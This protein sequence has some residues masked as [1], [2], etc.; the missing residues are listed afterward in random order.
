[1]VN[2]KLKLQWNTM[3]SNKDTDTFYIGP[4]YSHAVDRTLGYDDSAIIFMTQVQ[5]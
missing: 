4:D 3:H 1:S 5:L 2:F